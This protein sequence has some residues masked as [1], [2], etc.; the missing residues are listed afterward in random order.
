MLSTALVFGAH[1]QIAPIE[2]TDVSPNPASAPSVPKWTAEGWSIVRIVIPATGK[3]EQ[4]FV[5][6]RKSAGEEIT[7]TE[8][9]QT[10][11]GVRLQKVEWSGAPVQARV[12]LAKGNE[13]A[14][15]FG[16]PNLVSRDDHLKPRPPYIE[17]EARFIELPDALALEKLPPFGFKDIHPKDERVSGVLDQKPF[18][19]LVRALNQAK[20]VSLLSTPRVTIKAA[21]RGLVEIIKEFRY[22]SSWN[23]PTAQEKHWTPREFEVR[24]LGVSLE[25]ESTVSEDSATLDLDVTAK[26]TEF[27]GFVDFITKK[28]LPAPVSSQKESPRHDGGGPAADLPPS[29]EKRT[30]PVLTGEIALPAAGG[31]RSLPIFHTRSNHTGVSIWSGQTIVLI[32]PDPDDA[33]PFVSSGKGKTLLVLVKATCREANQPPEEPAQPP[34][35]P[36]LHQ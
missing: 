7:L 2:K 1:E 36:P 35:D 4:A 16:A 8:G 14:E 15:L 17:V 28:P 3:I 31:E 13:Q 19:L 25:V 9:A 22:P 23:P 29:G 33:A 20:G 21:Q 6:L 26:V 27:A 5:T 12:R 30:S 24:N 32:L 34:G 18:E 10:K 11:D